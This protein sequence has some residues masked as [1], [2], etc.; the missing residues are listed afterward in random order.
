MDWRFFEGV[1]C[2][3]ASNSVPRF[4]FENHIKELELF[5]RIKEYFDL[6]NCTGALNVIPPRK[7]R[8]NTSPAFEIHTIQELQK[9]VVPLFSKQNLLQSK[10]R[11]DFDSWAGLVNIYYFGSHLLPEGK[12]L[13]SEIKKSWNNFRLSSFGSVV[14]SKLTI[15]LPE[16]E[17]SF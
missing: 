3:S 16:G 15:K 2:F 7:N 14:P 4:K 10:K 9:G 1:G 12:H 13:I 5:K 8:D 6:K 17:G 11:K